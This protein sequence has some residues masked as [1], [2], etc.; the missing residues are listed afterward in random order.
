MKGLSQMNAVEPVRPQQPSNADSDAF[1][2][3]AAAELLFVRAIDPRTGRPSIIKRVLPLRAAPHSAGLPLVPDGFSQLQHEFDVLTRLTGIKGVPRVIRLDP[4]DRELVM[5][6]PG[7]VDLATAGLAAT[8]EWPAYLDLAAALARL[9]GAV[10][11]HGVVHR[12]IGPHTLWIEPAALQPSIVGFDHAVL[13]DGPTSVTQPPQDAGRVGAD[14]AFISPEQTGRMNRPVDHRSDL[15]SLGVVLYELATGRLPFEPSDPLSMR[16][17]HLARTPIEPHQVRPA[18]QH[19]LSAVLKRLLNKEPDGRYQRAESLARD[20]TLLAQGRLIE[21]QIGRDEAQA[22][23]QRPTRLHGMAAHSTFLREMC[24]QAAR[25]GPHLLLISGPPG[26]GKSALALQAAQHMAQANGLFISGRFS[27]FR[28]HLPFSAPLQALDELCGLLLAGDK[29]SLARWKARLQTALKTDGGVLTRLS[30]ALAALM[31][32]Q[33]PVPTLT[34]LDSQARLLG[35]LQALLR[36][37]ASAQQPL[38]LFLD[39]LQWAD[40]AS[41]AFMQSLLLQDDLKWLLLIGAWRSDVV[42]PEH[43]LQRMVDHL[44]M[45]SSA[46][47]QLT[48]GPLSRQDFAGLVA[49]TLSRPVEQVQ[50]LASRLHAQTEGNPH[51]AIELVQALHAEG[52]LPGAAAQPQPD[53]SD[54]AT[55]PDRKLPELLVRRLCGLDPRVQA[56]LSLAATL[57]FEFTLGMLRLVADMADARMQDG[58]RQLVDAGVLATPRLAPDQP[59]DAHT[60]YQFC[61]HHMQQ[62]A[63]GLAERAVRRAMHLH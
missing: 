3:S 52:A 40:L 27:Q 44:C 54:L 59:A 48:L 23:P 53:A 46:V 20:L 11:S 36:E 26:V 57:G 12:R 9:L 45:R 55:A 6:D 13:V 47:R 10:H 39:D 63:Y 31:G 15:Y 17:A 61:H 60:V 16:H 1:D 41:L 19:L 35:A 58:L 38:V 62:A 32:S 30:P 14:L 8:L 5:L 37:V 34:P 24:E 43:P 28:H 22:P 2:A 18:V 29:S 21:S 4:V 7:G 50:E 56:L 42:P 51:H 25:G 33:P 49:D